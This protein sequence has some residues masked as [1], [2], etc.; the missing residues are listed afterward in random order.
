MH[1]VP[2]A[3]LN[4]EHILYSRRH[5]DR[6]WGVIPVCVAWILVNEAL[7]AWPLKACPWRQ[8]VY[9]WVG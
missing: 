5:T 4:P 6:E 3:N 9:M 1:P 2:E 8:A 7:H